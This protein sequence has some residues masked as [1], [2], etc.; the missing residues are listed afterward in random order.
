M[1]L[2]SPNDIYLCT[3]LSCKISI[4]SGLCTSMY[5]Y[6]Y[7]ARI[8]LPKICKLFSGFRIRISRQLDSN[9]GPVGLDLDPY[10]KI[11]VTDAVLKTWSV[12]SNF[13]FWFNLYPSPIISEEERGEK[14]GLTNCLT[15]WCCNS[16][17]GF[18]GTGD[19][20]H[21]ESVFNRQDVKLCFLVGMVSIYV[22]IWSKWY[23]SN[24]YDLTLLNPVVRRY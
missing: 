24:P 13:N 22:V 2:S 23:P 3:Y 1:H 6:I 5:T 8:V 17:V 16:F 20:T 21:L 15:I 11:F 4:L 9:L 12:F 10:L 14:K 19:W 18:I 7:L